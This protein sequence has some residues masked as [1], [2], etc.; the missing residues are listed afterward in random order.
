MKRVTRA[1]PFRHNVPEDELKGA[2]RI[3]C[4]EVRA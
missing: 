1:Y 3:A 2:G 4:A